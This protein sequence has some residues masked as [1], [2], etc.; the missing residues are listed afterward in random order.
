MYSCST[1][2]SQKIV[3]HSSTNIKQKKVPEKSS[4]TFNFVLFKAPKKGL[5]QEL[6]H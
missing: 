4:G 1:A 3:E 5:L 6:A 2:G